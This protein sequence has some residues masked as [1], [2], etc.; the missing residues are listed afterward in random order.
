MGSGQVQT[1]C[2]FV[3]GKDMH[4][5][6]DGLQEITVYSL[7]F[8]ETGKP[9]TAVTE[10]QICWKLQF[11]YPCAADA[12]TQ[13]RE[14]AVCLLRPNNLVEFNKFYELLRK[15]N[16]SLTLSAVSL[17]ATFTDCMGETQTEWTEAEWVTQGPEN[18]TLRKSLPLGHEVQAGPY[19]FKTPYVMGKGIKP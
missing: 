12:L 3:K 1:N 7:L 16:S 18:T 5:F 13:K 15:F 2:C 4:L 9:C 19:T 8:L 10:C 6:L 14:A 11:W 17:I